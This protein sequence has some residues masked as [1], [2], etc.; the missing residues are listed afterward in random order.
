MSFFKKAGRDV[1]SIFK[2][3]GNVG[4][5]FFKKGGAGRQFSKMAGEVSGVTFLQNKHHYY[6]EHFSNA[7]NN[8][9]QHPTV[10]LKLT[11]TLGI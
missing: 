4:Q 1:G 5:G 3:A 8:S 2:K 6:S 7:L 9:P 10:C 11:L